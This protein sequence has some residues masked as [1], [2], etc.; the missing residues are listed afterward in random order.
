MSS[1]QHIGSVGMLESYPQVL[2][3]Q[4]ARGPAAIMRIF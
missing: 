2:L 3:D 1:F 4:S